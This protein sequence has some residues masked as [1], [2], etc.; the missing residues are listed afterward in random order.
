MN[1]NDIAQLAAG[2]GFTGNDVD[3]AVAVALAESGGDPGAINP[4]GSYGLWQIYVPDHPEFAGW[5]LLDPQTNARAAYQVYAKA[6]NRFRPW[7][8]FKT[9]AYR[10]FLSPF[11]NSAPAP[12]LVLDASTGLPVEDATVAAASMLPPS[13]GPSFGTVL[14]WAALGFFTLWI[15]EEA[16]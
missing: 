1:A 4:E 2:A 5:N 12:P 8:T 3:I 13:G 10:A 14:L 9:G 6:G 16:L 15:F 11:S 7:T